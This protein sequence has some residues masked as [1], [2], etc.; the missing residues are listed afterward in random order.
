[1]RAH[2]TEMREALGVALSKLALNDQLGIS[3]VIALLA[4]I[5]ER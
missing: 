2:D 5:A 3:R 1:M 4:V